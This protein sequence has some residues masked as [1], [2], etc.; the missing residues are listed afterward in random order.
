MIRDELRVLLVL[1]I[2]V[3]RHQDAG[4]GVI[5]GRD[6]REPRDDGGVDAAAQSDDEAARAGV[7][8]SIA[9][10][11]RDVIRMRRH[12]AP[13]VAQSTVGMPDLIGRYRV[14][15]AARRRRNGRRLRGARRSAGSPDRDQDDAGL[16]SRSRASGCCA[17]RGPPRRV[18]H[19][20]ICQLYEIG[21]SDGELFLAMELLDGEPLA[22][23]MARG[24]MTVTEAVPIALSIL[25]ALGALHAAGLVHRDLKPSNMFLTPG[26]VKLLDFGLAARDGRLERAPSDETRLTLPGVVIGTPQYMAPEQATGGTADAPDG[27]VRARRDPVRGA[28]RA[29]RLRRLDDRRRAARRRARASSGAERIAGGLGRRSRAASRAGEAARR[30]ISDG[31]RRWRARCGPRWRSPKPVRSRRARAAVRLIVLPFRLLRPD[32]Q[33]DWLPF[34]LADAITG[35]LSRL[36]T[37]VVR[38]SL[39]AARFAARR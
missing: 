20:N 26:G 32:P 21:E 7:G 28:R 14:L 36:E 19:A 9:H 39:A 3:T 37:L 8:E 11:R 4:H 29:A 34:S 12:R 6:L 23:R 5:A 10:P 13:I 25:D 18:S 22:A 35:S 24:P 17:R 2:A 15:E 1:R 27:S 33:V 16:R 31:R 30:A 38:S